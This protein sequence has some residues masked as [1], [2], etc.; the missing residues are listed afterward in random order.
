M[1]DKQLDEKVLTEEDLGTVQGAGSK[2]QQA[3]L[4]DDKEKGVDY[5]TSNLTAIKVAQDFFGGLKKE[6]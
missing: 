6:K 1:E 4:L 5:A 3:A 2:A